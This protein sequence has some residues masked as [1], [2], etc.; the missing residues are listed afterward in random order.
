MLYKRGGIFYNGYNILWVKV[1]SIVPL[2]VT[3]LTFIWGGFIPSILF[4]SSSNL[5]LSYSSIFVIFVVGQVYP[6]LVLINLSLTLYWLFFYAWAVLAKAH[7]LAYSLMIESSTISTSELKSSSC[8]CLSWTSSHIFYKAKTS[9]SSSSSVISDASGK[10]GN[11]IVVSN[12]SGLKSLIGI[13][14][15]LAANLSDSSSA[16]LIFLYL[17]SSAALS[18]STI[19]ISV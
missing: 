2:V 13:E 6:T 14:Y 5:N 9:L 15:F 18:A 1:I 11:P 4:A 17:S 10:G 12:Y 19:L 16:S 7:S 8:P 3:G